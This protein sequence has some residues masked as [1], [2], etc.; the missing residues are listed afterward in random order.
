MSS[1]HNNS[2]L[3]VVLTDEKNAIQTINFFTERSLFKPAGASKI[4]DDELPIFYLKDVIICKSDQ[5]LGNLLNAEIEGPFIV[6]GQLFFDDE[7]TNISDRK[8]LLQVT[9]HMTNTCAVKNPKYKHENVSSKPLV[10]QLREI[11]RSFGHLA[12]TDGLSYSRL[13]KLMN[14]TSRR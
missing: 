13:Q 6:R 1:S 7:A 10:S 14:P 12:K 4:E 2:P 3:S 8:S 9:L 5:T 11:Q